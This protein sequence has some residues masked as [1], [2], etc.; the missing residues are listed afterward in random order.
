LSPLVALRP[1]NPAAAGAAPA[2]EGDVRPLLRRRPLGRTRGTIW[3]SLTL[4][5]VFFAWFG[6]RVGVAPPPASPAIPIGVTF[7][8]PGDDA[9]APPAAEATA[10]ATAT[11]ATSPA[12]DAVASGEPGAPRAA[13]AAAATVA[14]T[15]AEPREPGRRDPETASASPPPEATAA[16]AFERPDRAPSGTIGESPPAEAAR[17]VAPDADASKIDEETDRPPETAKSV[18]ADAA[19]PVRPDDLAASE[20]MAARVSA[21]RDAR[22]APAADQA[23]ATAAAARG[24]AAGEAELTAA[25]ELASNASPGAASET[26]AGLA[27]QAES[28][29]ARSAAASSARPAAAEAA[30][31]PGAPT[32]AFASEPPPPAPE[33][34]PPPLPPHRPPSMSA[35]ARNPRIASDNRRI[36]GGDV[37]PQTGGPAAP[38]FD[39]ATL[40]GPR[41]EDTYGSSGG[42]PSSRQPVSGELNPGAGDLRAQPIAANPPPAYPLA[43][44]ERRIEGDVVLRVSVD[45]RGFVRGVEVARSSGEPMLDQA[46]IAAA[47]AWR[48][49][50]AERAG[51]RVPDTVE[52]AISFRLRR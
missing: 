51:T 29:V 43:A 41:F 10:A 16:V 2:L 36:G 31:T 17:V 49:L 33:T 24:S 34:G 28:E 25:P 40:I 27:S 50:P 22:P 14:A 47:R 8:M 12:A 6:A 9:Y 26:V 46:A 42:R 39:G 38:R 32:T 48:F 3:L 4:H 45:A 44:R 19:G 20:A 35:A 21:I 15:A 30:A 37:A 7:I 52:T 1:E 18:D 13:E 11:V 5:A 23:A